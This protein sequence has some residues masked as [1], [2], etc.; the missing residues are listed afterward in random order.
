MGPTS[1]VSPKKSCLASRPGGIVKSNNTTPRY[2]AEV[3]M[4]RDGEGAHVGGDMIVAG[5]GEDF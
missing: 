2:R 1:C 5:G 4:S 3:I